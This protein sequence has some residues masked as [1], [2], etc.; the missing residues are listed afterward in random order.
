MTSIPT[1]VP[2]LGVQR[3]LASVTEL[4][5]ECR[6]GTLR[7]LVRRTSME[8]SQVAEALAE[9]ETRGAVHRTDAGGVVQYRLAP[10]RWP[11]RPSTS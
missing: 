3:V 11:F 10:E 6:P 8:P 5:C 1:E 9:L 2:A 4:Q 7:E